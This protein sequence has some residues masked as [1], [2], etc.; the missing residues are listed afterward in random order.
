MISSRSWYGLVQ[1][2]P[3]LFNC[4]ILENI[5]YSK[6]H[7]N[8]NEFRVAEQIANAS[9]FIKSFKNEDSE[10][11]FAMSSNNNQVNENNEHLEI[12]Y[13][14]LNEGYK[15]NW[16]SRGGK[17]SGVQKQRIAIARA[18]CRSPSVLLLDKATSALDETSQKEVQIALD[19]VAQ[20]STWIIIVHRLSTLAKWNRILQFEQGIIVSEKQ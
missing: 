8:S 18:L 10:Y 19:S 20:K 15:I 3:L 13:S 11:S 17:L 4:S 1:Q 7:A 2:E 14:E 16:G 12:L 9:E 6:Q 5:I